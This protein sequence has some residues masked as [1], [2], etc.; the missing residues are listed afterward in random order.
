MRVYV[1]STLSALAAAQQEGAVG[2]GLVAAGTPLAAHAVTPA[3]REWYTE[4]DAEQ[5]EYAALLD[6]AEASLRLIAADAGAP[7]RRVVLAADIEDASVRTAAGVS[8][9]DEARSSVSVV[10]PVPLRAVVSVHVDDQEAEVDVG[11]AA[12]ALA[13][14]DAGDEEAQFVVDGAEGHD[15]LWYDVSE[16]SDLIDPF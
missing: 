6:A 2:A 12:D 8:P 9:L 10:V 11:A 15:L 16:L 3:L 4:G 1:P 7:R 14:A 5:L 13:A